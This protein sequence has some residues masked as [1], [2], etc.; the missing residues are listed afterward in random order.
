MKRLNKDQRLVW[1]NKRN[2]KDNKEYRDS[3]T[4]EAKK[5]QK[6]KEKREKRNLSKETHNFMKGKS[7]TYLRKQNSN[8]LNVRYVIVKLKVAVKI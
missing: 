3:R 1:K 2:R 7:L 4:E 5:Y 8:W 6:E